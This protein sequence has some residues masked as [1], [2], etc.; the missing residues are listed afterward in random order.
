MLSDVIR[1]TDK[2]AKSLYDF[3]DSA[4]DAGQKTLKLGDLI[5][6]NLIL[7]AIVV[8]LKLLGSA[9]MDVAGKFADFVSIGVS[10]TSNLAESQNVVD[11]TFVG[12]AN[13]INQ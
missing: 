1:A 6:S 12:N 9:I 3:G 10:N 13:M 5:K 7:E 11:V 2:N 4:N 8:D